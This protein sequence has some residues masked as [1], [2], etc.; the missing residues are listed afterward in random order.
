MKEAYE[1]SPYKDAFSRIESIE[2]LAG[3]GNVGH[4]V[5]EKTMTQRYNLG[6]GSIGSS[7]YGVNIV[8]MSDGTV[9]KVVVK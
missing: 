4:S 1:A 3:I 2:D 9:K 8:R 7:L 5:S 6:G